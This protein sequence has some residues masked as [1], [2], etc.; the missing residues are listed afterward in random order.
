MVRLRGSA[1]SFARVFAMMKEKIKELWEAVRPF[2]D[3]ALWFLFP[4]YGFYI[5]WRY[6]RQ[7]WDEYRQIAEAGA[8]LMAERSGMSEEDQAEMLKDMREDAWD[9][10]DKKLA[11]KKPRGGKWV[12]GHLRG[13]HRVR[14][15][16]R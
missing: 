14:G 12:R 16:W 9:R 8:L 11:G 13:G 10:A 5:G 3:V 6:V 7:N 1:T 2:L 15:Y 4:P